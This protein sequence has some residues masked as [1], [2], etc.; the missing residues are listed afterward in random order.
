VSQF[1]S[2]RQGVGV[3][4]VDR[5]DGR[6]DGPIRPQWLGWKE[7]IVIVD[8]AGYKRKWVVAALCVGA[9]GVA[10][11][12]WMTP[13]SLQAADGTESEAISVAAGV[14]PSYV[15]GRVVETRP[16]QWELKVGVEWTCPLDHNGV[17]QAFGILRLW[18]PSESAWHLDVPCL[19]NASVQPGRPTLQQVSVLWDESSDVHQWLRR[20]TPD[21]V[22]SAFI[23]EWAKAVEAPDSIAQAGLSRVD[24]SRSAR[25]RSQNAGVST[26][27]R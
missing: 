10:S 4:L 23:A 24:R 25:S 14:F 7:G 17:E 6:P 11:V 5:I 2:I 13:T 15:G 21:Q 1:L 19:L 18:S 20:A 3:L 12:V 16:G 22:R 9:L 26:L 27:P 8:S